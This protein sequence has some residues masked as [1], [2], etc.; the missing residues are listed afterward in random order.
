MRF[1]LLSIHRKLA[2]A[3]RRRV[4]LPCAHTTRDRALRPMRTRRSLPDLG[5]AFRN[6]TKSQGASGSLA[7][8]REPAESRV[9]TYVQKRKLRHA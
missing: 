2:A 9:Y 1:T 8:S 5:F 6:P 7:P 3:L 4:R